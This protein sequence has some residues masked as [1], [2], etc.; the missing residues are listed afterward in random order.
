MEIWIII[1]LL[2]ILVVYFIYWLISSTIYEIVLFV[3]TRRALKKYKHYCFFCEH[4]VNSPYINRIPPNNY[5][6]KKHKQ[7]EV[8]QPCEDFEYISALR[9]NAEFMTK[10][11]IEHSK[12]GTIILGS[13]VIMML[14][15]L[16]LVF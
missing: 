2:V 16:V 10:E 14:G 11:Y 12:I 1:I 8:F 3:I 6:L 5:C 9:G 13:T 4:L 15:L 7:L